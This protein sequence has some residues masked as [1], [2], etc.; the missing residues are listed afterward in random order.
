MVLSHP[1]DYHSG[2]REAHSRRPNPRTA[3]P[4]GDVRSR[5]NPK[6]SVR[7]VEMGGSVIWENLDM[8]VV[9]GDDTVIFKCIEATTLDFYL[10]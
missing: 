7:V 5:V 1:S 10:F 3:P 8:E 4:A 2:R 6:L 9:E